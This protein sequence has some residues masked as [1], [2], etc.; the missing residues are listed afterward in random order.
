MQ[1]CLNVALLGRSKGGVCVMFLEAPSP[2]LP[3]KQ[4]RCF[5]MISLHCSKIDTHGWLSHQQ[6]CIDCGSGSEDE[7]IN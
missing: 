7:L 5:Q 4:N 6:Y 1:G 3:E 2:R